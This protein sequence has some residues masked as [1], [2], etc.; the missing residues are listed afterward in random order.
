MTIPTTK[1]TKLLRE[2]RE[3]V[4]PLP[5]AEEYVMVHH[6][7]FRVGKKPFAVVGLNSRQ[8]AMLSI[9]LGKMEQAELLEDERFQRTPYI[10]Q[11]GWVSVLRSQLSD[12]ELW[13][14]VEDSWRRVATKRLLKEYESMG[15]GG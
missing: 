10:G 11:H 14:L 4:E 12:G 7:A 2:L 3:L 9:N 8:E 15:A 13:E 5:G 6:P 1:N